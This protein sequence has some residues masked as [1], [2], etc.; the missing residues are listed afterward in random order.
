MPKTLIKL[1]IFYFS[2]V[3]YDEAYEKQLLKRFQMALKKLKEIK[4]LFE[5]N[6]TINQIYDDNDYI[7]NKIKEMLS[8]NESKVDIFI[9]QMIIYFDIVE[10][11]ELIM[12]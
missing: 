12:I 8:N 3:L 5:A 7:F 10:K 4:N 9:R 11:K 6:Y 2:K 1:K